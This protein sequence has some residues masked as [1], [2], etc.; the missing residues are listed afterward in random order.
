MRLFLIGALVA[1]LLQ[2]AALGSILYERVRL[3]AGG[4]E[5]TIRSGMR[6][7]R[8]L[9]RGNYV[10]LNLDIGLVDPENWAQ[11]DPAPFS[12]VFVELKLGTDGLWVA[13]KVH[14]SMPEKP[15]GPVLKGKT[16]TS[17]I[18]DGV[19]IYAIDL[20]FDRYFAPKDRALELER[21]GRV[22]QL[23]VILSV[24]N[25]GSAAIKGIVA[26]DVRIYDVPVL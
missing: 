10:T 15:V 11:G 16:S 9:F 17:T 20:P 24:G 13:D 1:A 12:P 21:L 18:R 4:T 2:S 3:L 6:D 19:V 22:G 5:V 7:P 14:R 8:D 25:D 23:A 26:D